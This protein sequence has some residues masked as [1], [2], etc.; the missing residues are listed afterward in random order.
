MTEERPFGLYGEFSDTPGRVIFDL[1][2]VQFMDED[3]FG[4]W[5]VSVRDVRVEEVGL[6]RGMSLNVYAPS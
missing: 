3:A 6:I 2:S 4:T 1:S 5:T